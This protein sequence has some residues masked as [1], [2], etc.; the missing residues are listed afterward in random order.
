MA[1]KWVKFIVGSETHYW[2]LTIGEHSNKYPTGNIAIDFVM[3]S[4]CNPDNK[5]E[6]MPDDFVPPKSQLGII[7]VCPN[8]S[9][10]S[11]ST[12]L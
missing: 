5:V 10:N 2:Y 9:S 3:S 11:N 6:I 8:D 7:N 4:P 1:K 12:S